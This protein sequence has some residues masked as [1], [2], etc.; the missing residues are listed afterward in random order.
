[1]TL[2]ITVDE[3]EEITQEVT[4]NQ[5]AA[6][7]ISVNAAATALSTNWTVFWL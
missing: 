7:E 4:A 3:E 1:M 6:R 2:K 5:A